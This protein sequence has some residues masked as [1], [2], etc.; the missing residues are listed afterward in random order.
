MFWKVAEKFA[1]MYTI[2]W[3]LSGSFLGL[4]IGFLNGFLTTV[5]AF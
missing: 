4:E 2:Y 1:D 3:R 5:A